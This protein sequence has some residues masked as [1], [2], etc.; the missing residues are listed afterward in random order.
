MPRKHLINLLWMQF[1]WFAAVLG[2]VSD[3]IWPALVVLSLFMAWQLYPTQRVTGDFALML[4][5][6]LLG[7]MLD[8]TWISL[9]WMQ[10]ASPA[11][12]PRL[13]PLW[14]LLLW[15]GLALT[16]NHS[17]AWLQNR[18]WLAGFSAAIASPLSYLGAERLGAVQITGNFY[19]WLFFIAVSW[20]IAVPT[21][22]WLA[23]A[24]R[25]DRHLC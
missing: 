8:S 5:A 11:P 14:I 19:L 9:G 6:V 7:F 18:L 15:M 12:I 4:V 3:L 20:A 1:L 23:R 22:L 10:F 25:G 13:A 2:A 21:L 16:L 24:L 17:L